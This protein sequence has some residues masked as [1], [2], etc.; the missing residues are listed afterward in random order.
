M[1]LY[2]KLFLNALVPSLF[3]VSLGILFYQ[4][5][6]NIKSNTER[7]LSNS[8]V[9]LKGSEEMNKS[10]QQIQT[11]TQELL[12][13]IQE[14]KL[15]ASD[16]KL[17]SQQLEQEEEE[18]K[19]RNEYQQE[20]SQS[21]RNYDEEEISSA[22][23][24]IRDNLSNF[25]RHLKSVKEINFKEIKN[26]NHNNNLENDNYEKKIKRLEII[27][28]EFYLYRNFLEN[29]LLL[30]RKNPRKAYIFLDRKLEPKMRNHLFPMVIKYH[31]NAL[32]ELESETKLV[33]NSLEQEN[34]YIISVSGLSFLAAVMI[35]GLISRSIY[36]PLERLN[37]SVSQGKKGQ[38]EKIKVQDLNDRNELHVLAQKYNQMVETLQ[39]TTVSKSYLDNILLSL[40]DSLIV[41]DLDGNINKIN[42]ATCDLLG[43]QENELIGQNIDL[44]LT[45]KT[46]S[47]QNLILQK[48]INNYQIT[49]HNKE[50]KKIPISFSSSLLFKE[51]NYPH[52]IVCLARDMT[53]KYLSEKALRESETR[54]A[55]AARAA[56]DG[57]W[58][59]DFLSN[60]IYFSPRWKSLLGYE[61][62]AI[63]NKPEEWF[64]RVHPEDLDRIS[65]AIISHLQNP[66]APLEIRYQ[67]QHKDNS[68]RW[69]LCRG[70]AVKDEKGKISRLTGSQTDIT[71]SQ[72]AQEKLRYQALYDGLTGL[73][74]RS[75]FLDK[76]N[77]L[78]EQTKKDPQK[79]F[80]ILFLDLDG[81]KKINDSLGHL[82]GDRLLS[83][84]SQRC[85][86]FLTNKATLA[87]LGGDE[88]AILVENITGIEDATNLAEK[89][90]LQLEK[91]FSLLERELFIR[92]SIGIAPWSNQ[93]HQV[94]D[95]LRDA[96]T[97]MY[98]AKANGKAHYVV[99]E[100]AMYFEAVNALDLEHDLHQGIEREEFEVFY[101][102]IVKLS[103]GQIVGF[104]ALTRWQHPIKG[105]ISPNQFIPIAEETGLILEIGIS[106]L[107]Q[108][109]YQMKQWQAKYEVA[110]DLTISVNLSPLQLKPSPSN[111]SYDCLESIQKIIEETGLKPHSLKLEIT[112]SAI[113]ESI[114][115]TNSLLE[116]IKAL[117]I[118]VSM[119]DFGTGY[120]SLNY[121][122]RLPIDTLKIDRSFVRELSTDS[123]KLSLTQ[124]II[125]LSHTLGMTVIAE[126]IETKDQQAILRELNC[127]YGQGYLFSKPISSTDAE[128]L[129]ATTQQ[130]TKHVL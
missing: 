80:A 67:M 123:K 22:S 6:L 20:L 73:P 19:E 23:Q 120:S 82:A 7:K 60:E 43:Y 66:I 108:A 129:I 125:N 51:K 86:Q 74:N 50:G 124:T 13:E 21:D 40:T 95:L 4:K 102:P 103:N 118:K 105:T 14:L 87:R 72:I 27:E 90:S 3:L 119:D 56:N 116:Q 42:Q 32:K 55:L 109:C 49:Y 12:L 79:R 34:Q 38:L 9:E 39:Q 78:F 75:F 33:R 64:K 71:Q 94:E 53:E 28:K 69:M 29:Y 104:E 113:I 117:G 110:R 107:K 48:E 52:A 130:I 2:Q 106:I 8:L 126:G 63:D 62:E 16:D 98:Q 70:I 68:Y 85:K 30:A 61:S 111:N 89:L 31:A 5:N 57:L 114:E 122:N 84:F 81:F 83:D 99:F 36:K 24:N 128:I 41:I 93:Y 92:V 26:Y 121:L 58:D 15:R 17:D 46:T 35:G 91:P 77:Q 97:A 1:K 101:Q 100:P 65:Q 59:W 10:L 127:E 54:Y 115:I 88:F 112:E 47:L 76:L 18:E 45:D 96:D 44:I 25:E 37:R 11:A